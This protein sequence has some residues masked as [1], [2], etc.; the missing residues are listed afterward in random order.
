VRI[1]SEIPSVSH[2]GYVHPPGAEATLSIYP[3]GH[4][5]VLELTVPPSSEG[6]DDGWTEQFLLPR[7]MKVDPMKPLILMPTPVQSATASRVAHFVVDTEK[8][9]VGVGVAM[10]DGRFEVFELGAGF[11]DA[12]G[13]PV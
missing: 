9:I 4:Y 8:R 1:V 6:A 11:V 10:D 2:P 12:K 5:R 7:G 13:T 3:G